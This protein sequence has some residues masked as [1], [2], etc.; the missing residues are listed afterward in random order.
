MNVVRC[1]GCG[2][3]V[4][5][6][7][8]R[9]EPRCL[10]CGSPALEPVPLAVDP[11]DGFLPFRVDPAAADAAFRA[12]ARQGLFTPTSLRDASL[13]LRRLLLPAWS[14]S[15]TLE[16][17]W[18]GLVA[19]ATRSGKRPV[20]GHEA[21]S[22]EGVLVP[23][24]ATLTQAE[25]SSLGRFDAALQPWTEA[26]ATDPWEVHALTR[27]GAR[28]AGLA[29]LRH[30]AGEAI[31]A[32]HGLTTA[33]LAARAT[34]LHGSPVLIPVWIGVYTWKGV[35]RR[36]L[37]HGL[38]GKVVGDRPVD[39]AKVL[40]AVGAVIGLILVLLTLASLGR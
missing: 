15:G 21:P 11:P 25:L 6:V 13:E 8:G 27:E 3:S 19:A 24:S 2:G 9:P 37:V 39:P 35:P 7:P 16:V 32:R 20:A 12:F 29:V 22:F 26:A 30:R 33:N 40:L 17:C 31:R 10:F 28:R 36:V 18:T 14:W 5:V 34:A 38:D 1:A 23:A 4:G